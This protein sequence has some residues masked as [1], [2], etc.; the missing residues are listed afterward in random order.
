MRCGNCK[1]W[2]EQTKEGG[3]Y[4]DAYVIR[5]RLG[6][7]M[8][9]R[10]VHEATKFKKNDEPLEGKEQY[11]ATS[12]DCLKEGIRL[13][14]IDSTLKMYTQDG[15]SY[16]ADLYTKCDFFCAHFEANGT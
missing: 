11:I 1:H 10:M 7:C 15:S 4:E 3:N 9:V 16:R 8:R 6:E 2:N 12:E 5:L 14:E 13:V